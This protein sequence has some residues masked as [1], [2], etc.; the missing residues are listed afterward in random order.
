MFA[1]ARWVLATTGAVML[2]ACATQQAPASWDGLERRDVKGID[3]VYVRP[4][5][6]F[7]HYKKVIIDPVQVS[8]SKNW[9]QNSTIELS[10]RLDTADLQ[11]IKDALGKLL[12]ERFTRELTAAG[13]QVTDVPADDTI[14][15]KPDIVNLYIN[16]PDVMSPGVSRSYTTN[17]GEMTLDMEVRDSPTGELLARVVDR[18]RALDTGR[19]QWTN[20]VTNT[21]DAER[22]IDVWAR[23]LRAG[24]DRVNG[25]NNP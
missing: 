9:N 4:N 22:A 15:V 18:Q 17:A 10:R 14:R 24:L 12:R 21:A 20:A 11:N 19:L 6:K 3:Q 7:P 16:A 2:A 5:F 8:F 25:P 1:A 23:Q 13:Y